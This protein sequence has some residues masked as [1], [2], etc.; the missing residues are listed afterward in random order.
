MWVLKVILEVEFNLPPLLLSSPEHPWDEQ[1]LSSHTHTGFS[2]P[3]YVWFIEVLQLWKHSGLM[4]HMVCDVEQGACFQRPTGT[5]MRQLQS[6][7]SWQWSERRLMSCHCWWGTDWKSHLRILSWGGWLFEWWSSWWSKSINH[8]HCSVPYWADVN[9]AMMKN[10]LEISPENPQLRWR[11]SIPHLSFSKPR[12]DGGVQSPSP[13]Y[14]PPPRLP[15]QDG[16]EPCNKILRWAF[17]EQN[18]EIWDLSF[19]NL[20]TWQPPPNSSPV[21]QD[22]SSCLPAP[23]RFWT[24]RNCLCLLCPRLST[25]WRVEDSHPRCTPPTPPT[26]ASLDPQHTW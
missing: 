2:S 11:S 17:F 18:P 5:R 24:W 4:Y 10:R 19:K 16:P 6:T 22:S 25:A 8:Q 20:F 13:A 12:R 3:L 26:L 9:T 7:W 23:P 15:T 1:V 21:W 14:P